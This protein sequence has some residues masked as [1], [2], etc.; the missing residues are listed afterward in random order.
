[1]TGPEQDRDPRWSPDGTKIAFLRDVRGVNQVVIVAAEGGGPAV[2][3]SRSVGIAD[4]DSFKW[5]PD[6]QILVVRADLSG[7]DTVLLVDA[8]DGRVTTLPVD[9]GGL[10]AFWRPPDGRELLFVTGSMAKQALTIY[11]LDTGVP[12]EVPL[13]VSPGDELRP[14]GWTPDGARVLVNRWSAADG[15]PHTHV[16]D[17]D[18]GLSTDLPVGFGHV[19]NAGDRVAGIREGAD[20]AI[21]VI[22]IDGGPCVPYGPA[23][24]QP[25]GFHFTDLQWS[26]DD[27]WILVGPLDGSQPV[28]LD[29]ISGEIAPDADWV[30]SGADSWRRDA[31]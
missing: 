5:S 22:D 15:L 31:P 26:P 9:S 21:C 30:K 13:K 4:P 19:S 14:M 23:W 7:V 11:P 3:S 17:P 29:A 2:V 12:R 27:R 8:D 6:S 20:E 16:I 18:T 24:A 1:V 25:G 28:L 10:E